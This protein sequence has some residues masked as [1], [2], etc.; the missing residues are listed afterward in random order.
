MYY[1]NIYC[2]FLKYLYIFTI[3]IAIKMK[4]YIYI[5]TTVYSVDNISVKLL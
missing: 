1:N 3:N 5:Q 4:K 2:V